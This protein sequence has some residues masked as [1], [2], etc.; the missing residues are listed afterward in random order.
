MATHTSCQ[1]RLQKEH[2]RKKLPRWDHL[3]YHRGHQAQNEHKY[4]TH[5][6]WGCHS[7]R[8]SKY[9]LGSC[10]CSTNTS[11]IVGDLF[12]KRSSIPSHQLANQGYFGMVKQPKIYANSCPIPWINYPGP[13]LVSAQWW[14]LRIWSQKAW[15]RLPLKTPT[16]TIIVLVLPSHGKFGLCTAYPSK[17]N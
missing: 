3:F 9:K 17:Q 16:R 2:R 5:Y 14:D 10:Q 15:V 1:T 12:V 7:P 11:V 13:G 8:W 4:L 6:H